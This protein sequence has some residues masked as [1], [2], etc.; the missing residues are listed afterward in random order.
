MSTEPPPDLEPSADSHATAARS[1]QALA[2]GALVVVAA[3]AAGFF[4]GRRDG[5]G[6]AKAELE[7]SRQIRQAPFAL[8]V[9]ADWRRPGR[10]AEVPGLVL[11]D[12]IALTPPPPGPKGTLIVG[13]A[14]ADDGSLLPATL[15]PHP[16]PSGSA[17]L[18]NLQSLRY[19]ALRPLGAGAPVEL[20]AG[21]TTGGALTAVC[22]G[23]DPGFLRSCR[24]AVATL[25]LTSGESYPLGPD[26][27]L[28]D[29]V[30]RAMRDLNA[31]RERRVSAMRSAR[32]PAAQASAASAIADA[33]TAAARRVGEASRNPASAEARAW[34]VFALGQAEAAWRRLAA[35]ASGKDGN[36]DDYESARADAVFS[37]RWV[38]MAAAR[39]GESATAT[40]TEPPA[41]STHEPARSVQAAG[42][43]PCSPTHTFDGRVPEAWKGY[44]RMC[45]N[46]DRT[47]LLVENISNV[48]LSLEHDGRAQDVTGPADSL[49]AVVTAEFARRACLGTPCNL[50]PGVSL[51]IDSDAPIQVRFGLAFNDT[52]TLAVASGIAARAESRL[53]P[54]SQR[55][56]A[57]VLGCATGVVS[58]FQQGES[59][60]Q[61]LRE[62]GGAAPAC[63]GLADEF[64][65][66]APREPSQVASVDRELA[67]DFVL[68]T[69]YSRAK[70]FTLTKNLTRAKSLLRPL[71]TDITL[72][73]LKFLLRFRP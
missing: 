66:P 3:A 53:K 41:P 72:G 68:T 45:A 11:A 22:A 12:P 42:S 19:E 33:Y 58:T 31:V 64:R 32:R 52:L 63:T 21:S 27:A 65:K 36:L 59:W 71:S 56:P 35:A 50:F 62:A 10:P 55:R 6:R 13:V 46:D 70:D 20:Y 26:R 4:L 2:V 8:R 5:D 43:K 60:E 34:L 16:R 61:V 25:R 23:D 73:G 47:S 9:P 28:R 37:E 49:S 1:R 30:D 15:L 40:P 54:K 39:A 38:G 7:K 18:G 69:D 51:R 67:K 29:T 14:T 48:V 24:A 17:R 44:V 57:Q